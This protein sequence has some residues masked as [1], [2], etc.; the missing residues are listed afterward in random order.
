[1]AD[2]M[3]TNLSTNLVVLHVVVIFTILLLLEEVHTLL[4]VGVG[5]LELVDHGCQL[6]LILLLHLLLLLSG[7]DLLLRAALL[8]ANAQCI[9]SSTSTLRMLAF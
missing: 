8:A 7:F 5:L 1:M 3:A 6:F 4:K 9:G 2:S